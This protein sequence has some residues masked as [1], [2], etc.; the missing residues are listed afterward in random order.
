MNVST[1]KVKKKKFLKIYVKYTMFWTVVLKLH[2]LQHCNEIFKFLNKIFLWRFIHKWWWMNIINIIFIWLNLVLRKYYY[3]YIYLFW[4]L[5]LSRIMFLFVIPIDVSLYWQNYCYCSTSS[6]INHWCLISLT[7]VL[8]YWEEK[9]IL[10]ISTYKNT[11]RYQ[12]H[13]SL[14]IAERKRKEREREREK[15]VCF[16][17]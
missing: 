9:M 10:G 16:S 8:K 4:F 3:I 17:M 5:N 15:T 11:D 13:L 6:S 7:N 2:M 14:S 12:K 1:S